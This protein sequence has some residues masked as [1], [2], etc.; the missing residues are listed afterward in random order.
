MTHKESFSLL[1]LYIYYFIIPLWPWILLESESC[2]IWILSTSSSQCHNI[3]VLVH[4][5][6]LPD[7]VKDLYYS[8]TYHLKSGVDIWMR[9]DVVPV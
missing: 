3:Q 5:R 7:H 6:K 2:W 1:L 9:V 4:P 8:Q